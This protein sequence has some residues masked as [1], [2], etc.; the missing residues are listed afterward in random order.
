ME[1]TATL[2][3][4][5]RTASASE[6]S[7]DFRA[8]VG[9]AGWLRL[10][11]AVRQRFSAHAAAAT[12][13]GVMHRV[14]CS[15]AGL[16]LAQLCRLIGSPF[17]TWRGRDVPVDILL[18]PVPG[19]MMWERRYHYPARAPVA[20]R[21]I[22]QAAPGRTGQIIERVGFGFGM[23]LDVFERDGALHFLSRRY[24]WRVGPA[25]LPLPHLLSPGVAHV[26]HT[27]LGSGRFRFEMTI[28]HAWLGLVFHQDGVFHDAQGEAP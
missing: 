11:P 17:A 20:V 12:Y 5:W 18:R 2:P 6:P 13:A 16:V 7:V 10:P 23:R 25:D 26:I 27:D 4:T 1:A 24:L 8:L 19:G 28:R 9:E 15:G 3:I 22:K 21:S 14:D